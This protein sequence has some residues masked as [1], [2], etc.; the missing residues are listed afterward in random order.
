MLIALNIIL[1]LLYLFGTSLSENEFF[2]SFL[3]AGVFTVLLQAL[4]VFTYKGKAPLLSKW[5]LGILIFIT[6]VY[7]A[8]IAHATALGKAY[9]H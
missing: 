2:L 7:A 6:L 8:F 1:C 4:F 9:Q 5:I 3:Y